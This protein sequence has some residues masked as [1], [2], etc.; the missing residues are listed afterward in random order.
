MIGQMKFSERYLKS[1]QTASKPILASEL[2]N[3]TFN[4][5]E[6][7]NY[8]KKRGVPVH[9]LTEDELAPFIHGNGD[10]RAFRRKH[11][12]AKKESIRID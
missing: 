4:I 12:A 10:W 3:V 8:A 7:I 11:G 9:E 2:P 5:N 1:V 6:I